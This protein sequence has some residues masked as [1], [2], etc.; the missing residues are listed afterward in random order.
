MLTFLICVIAD[1]LALI[2]MHGLPVY[3]KGG[4]HFARDISRKLGRSLFISLTGFTSSSSIDHLLHLY[5]RLL[6]LFYL[7]K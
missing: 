5:A 4:F 1:I 6:M 7:P 2:H 3:V